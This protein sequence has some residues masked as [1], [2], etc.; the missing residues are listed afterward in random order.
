MCTPLK[1][2]DEIEMPWKSRHR[3]GQHFQTK[4]YPRTAARSRAI[5]AHYQTKG[6]QYK[7]SVRFDPSGIEDNSK[8]WAK[9]RELKDQ[10]YDVKK[11]ESHNYVRFFVRRP[12]GY[13]P[14]TKSFKVYRTTIGHY[15]GMYADVPAEHFEAFKSQFPKSEFPRA[16][17]KLEDVSEK[18]DWN[19]AERFNKQFPDSKYKIYQVY[20]ADASKG[21]K[22]LDDL[23]DSNKVPRPEH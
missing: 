2:R 11:V 13:N 6:W 22:R 5:Q 15:G 20:F 7:E 23:I 4:D 3:D 10:G 1:K 12:K 19:S 16:R 14:S 9:E 21:A 18:W 17:V 8:V